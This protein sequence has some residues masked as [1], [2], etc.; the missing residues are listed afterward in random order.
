MP[1]DPKWAQ[2]PGEGDAPQP[3]ASHATPPPPPASAPTT[4]PPAAP[5]GPAPRM[6][7]GSPGSRSDVER[8]AIETGAQLEEKGRE[9]GRKLDQ[10]L[11]ES[12][13]GREIKDTASRWWKKIQEHI[14]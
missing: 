14:K 4:P 6:A 1:L 3:P 13:T 7:S 2:Q 12:E 5:T 9:L 8:A 11:S 10:K